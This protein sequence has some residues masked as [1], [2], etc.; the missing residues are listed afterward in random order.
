M[1]LQGHKTIRKTAMGENISSIGSKT[2]HA[3]KSKV[4]PPMQ[5]Y[6]W[7]PISF[8]LLINALPQPWTDNAGLLRCSRRAKNEL[9]THVLRDG[10]WLAFEIF[11]LISVVLF[12]FS[13][14]Y[15]TLFCLRGEKAVKIIPFLRHTNPIISKLK[16]S[17]KSSS[18]RNECAA[19]NLL[20]P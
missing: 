19:L 8:S 9:K 13:S 17:T 3:F 5:R 6:E 12:L 2:E 7:N 10:K 20:P 4:N 11:S 1:F 18:F 15:Y 16:Q 14:R